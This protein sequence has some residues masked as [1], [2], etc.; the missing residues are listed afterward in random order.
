MYRLL[1]DI[2]L[3]GES[4][5]PLFNDPNKPF[6][7][8]FN[9]EGN[10]ISN[11]KINA[12]EG[13]AGLFGSIGSSGIIKNLYLK[14]C[15]MSIPENASASSGVGNIAGICIGI[16]SDC[17]V[18]N[19]NILNNKNTYT[20]GIVGTLRNGAIINCFIKKS[21]I[22]TTSASLGGFVGK[23][24][25]GDIINCYSASNK[26]TRNTNYCGG[27]CGFAEN[28][29]IINS[30]VYDLTF[31]SSTNTGQ[32]IGHGVN[33]DVTNCYTDTETKSYYLINKKEGNCTSTP[34]SKYNSDFTN[35]KGSVYNQLNQWITDNQSSYNYPFTI[36]TEDETGTLPAI[37]VP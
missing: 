1:A 12:K 6:N 25:T 18:I 20:G 32:F 31:K 29:K 17:G 26:I 14:D 4:I 34:N 23:I 37:F 10:T 9:G 7:H 3:N 11:F 19:G 21:E 36:W 16:I 5:Y 30:Y 13:F 2:D 33:S 35:S 15:S 27:F 24:E 22:K 28:G 8:I